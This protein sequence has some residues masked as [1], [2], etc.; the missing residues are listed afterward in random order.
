MHTLQEVEAMH[1]PAQRNV[2]KILSQDTRHT[3]VV[4]LACGTHRSAMVSREG[5]EKTV[6]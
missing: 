1:C 5:T 6:L 4:N 3:K 2:L